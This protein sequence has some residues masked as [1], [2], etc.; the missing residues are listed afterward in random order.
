MSS[1]IELSSQE[2]HTRLLHRGRR[3]RRQHKKQGEEPR[4]RKMRRRRAWWISWSRPNGR[5]LQSGGSGSRQTR[6][7]GSHRSSP[8]ASGAQL[9]LPLQQSSNRC[10]MALQPFVGLLYILPWQDLQQ[11]TVVWTRHASCRTIDSYFIDK[12]YNLRCRIAGGL[13]WLGVL[14][15]GVVSEQVKTRLENA[16]EESNTKVIAHSISVT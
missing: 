13:A 10:G 11:T 8:G 4:S 16:A 5:Q 3:S 6:R 9:G 7:T 14:T 1:Y 12:K 2:G 15:F